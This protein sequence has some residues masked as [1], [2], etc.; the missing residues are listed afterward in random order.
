M[1]LITASKE[2]MQPYVA[3][4]IEQLSR[5]MLIISKNPSNPIFN[6]YLFESVGA[7]VR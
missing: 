7:L 2:E 6:H 1:R 5:I 4:V 3:N